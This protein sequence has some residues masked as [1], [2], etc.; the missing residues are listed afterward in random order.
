MRDLVALVIP[1]GPR[2]VSELEAAWQRGDAV[3]PIDT[4]LGDPAA[5]AVI[6]AME[7]TVVVD[8][9]GQHTRRS[10]R[11]VD[12]GDALVVTTSGT[13]GEPKGIVLTHGQVRAS[14]L[15]TTERLGLDPTGDRWLA[16]LP[17]SHVGGLSVVTRALVTGTALEVIPGFD[18]TAVDASEATAVSLVPT[19]LARIDARRWK[20]IVLGGSAP[21][22]GLPPNVVTTYGLTETGSGVVYDRR[23]LAGVEITVVDEEIWLRGPMVATHRRDGT[24]VVDD[25][26]WLHT[27]DLGTWDGRT[28]QVFGRADDLIKTGGEKVWPATVETVLARHPKVAEVAVVG[29]ADPEWGQQV[30]AVVVPA[31]QPP[32]LAELRA[33]VKESL[34]PWCAPKAL[35]LVAALPRTSIGKVRRAGL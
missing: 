4:R 30:V 5:L 21:P 10:G 9:H 23:P 32:E 18:A 15:A 31:G 33:W 25:Q 11:P 26:G 8:R 1:G 13:T 6:E 16:C 34:P 2:F 19:A 17:L 27:G 7:A 14:A 20:V 35:E 24:P 29:R 12:D 3:L 22:D 28:L